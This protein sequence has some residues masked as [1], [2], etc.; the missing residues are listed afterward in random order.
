MPSNVLNAPSTADPAEVI[1]STSTWL[2]LRLMPPIESIATD[3]VPAEMLT[4]PAVD[5]SDV[6]PPPVI[7]SE[8]EKPLVEMLDAALPDRLNAPVDWL[9][10]PVTVVVAPDAPMFTAD[11]FCA[12][13]RTS[14]PDWKPSMMI[15]PPDEP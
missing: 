8:D 6:L 7:D 13:M 11:T 10:A 12:P 15:A 3:P 9:N 14:D 1:V 2:P 5:E 4:L